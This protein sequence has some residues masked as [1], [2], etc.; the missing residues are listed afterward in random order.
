MDIL[1]LSAKE[2]LAINVFS[3]MFTGEDD[4]NKKTYRLLLKKWH[5]DMNSTDTS[6]VFVHINQLYDGL[7]VTNKP[8]LV[9]INGKLY[10]Y[11]YSVS[12]DLYDI[13]YTDNGTGFLINFKQKNDEIRRNYMSNLHSLQSLL[14][15]HSF[16]DRYKDLLTCKAYE[17]KEFVKV[18]VPKGYV[19]LNL[20]LKYIIDF[21]DWKIS[22]YI[23]SR[24][25]DMAMLYKNAKLSSIG[26][27]LDFIFVNTKK[28]QIIDLSALFLSN[29]ID[30]PLSLAL[31]P[32]QASS[33]IKS[34]LQEKQCS[35]TSINSMINSMGLVLAGDLDRV[36][37]VNLLDNS[38]NKQMV[39]II[40]G[41]NINTP[42]H[43]NYELWQTQLV[44]RL[45]NERSFYKKEI[46]FGDLTKYIGS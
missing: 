38:A 2:I 33:F 34:D 27:D 21:K 37:N 26:F 25:Y 45:F 3:E 19:P 39:S 4:E 20:L 28:H 43:K 41:I 16:E 23:I 40:S 5:P 15:G 35:H 17:N 12:K 1:N 30:K 46:V 6:N 13:Y 18:R 42:I 32:M 9:E 22:A 14:K 8:K 31:T 36:S 10:D 44:Q 11:I 7:I 29:P 24:L